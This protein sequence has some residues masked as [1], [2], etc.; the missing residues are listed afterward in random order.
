MV[1]FRDLRIGMFSDGLFSK[2]VNVRDTIFAT[3]LVKISA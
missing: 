1:R 2:K 3:N